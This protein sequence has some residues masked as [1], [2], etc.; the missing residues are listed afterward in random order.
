M[1]TQINVGTDVPFSKEELAL[2][3][4]IERKANGS[5]RLKREGQPKCHHMFLAYSWKNREVSN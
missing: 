2:F 4:E 3:D 1:A 5:A